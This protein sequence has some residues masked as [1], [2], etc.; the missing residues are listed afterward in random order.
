MFQAVSRTCQQA[1]FIFK[2]AAVADYTPAQYSGD[3]MKKKDG[4]LSIP[5]SRTHDILSYLG[6][7]RR[8]GQFICGF[9]METRD[10]VEN[11][12]AKLEKK[13]G[14]HDLRQQ[15][16]GGRGRL[17]GGYHVLTLITADGAEE[18]PL[19]SKEEAAGTILDQ[20]PGANSLVSS[21]GT[22]RVT[23]SSGP[24]DE[25][26][27]PDL[28]NVPLQSALSQLNGLGEFDI[29][30]TSRTDYD[31]HIPKDSVISTIPAKDQPLT[32]GTKI[33]LTIS[34]GKEEE[35]VPMIDLRG[36]TQE[37]AE[38]AIVGL[39]L[40]VGTVD[41]SSSDMPPGRSGSSPWSP[42]TR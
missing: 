28:T 16:E 22:I 33:Y 6:E 42:R 14:G 26:L 37:Q 11:S 3:K 38:K 27:M 13:K 21:S 10:M 9:S 36:M 23:V 20:D 17:R 39:G 8:P 29:D 41:H 4:D 35:T 5:L 31:D 19:M 32:E 18:L 12:R 40:T 30:F 1:D 15:P 34:L 25:V 7:H 24:A 2:A